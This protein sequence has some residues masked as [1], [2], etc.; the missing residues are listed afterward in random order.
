VPASWYR[1]H[2]HTHV[3]PR[4]PLHPSSSST[5]CP[6]CVVPSF[7][8]FPSPRPSPRDS[9]KNVILAGVKAVT[10]QDTAACTLADLG[11][12]FYLTQ[13]DVGTNRAQACAAKLQELNP[14]VAVTFV[15]AEISDDL[16]KKH[17]VCAPRA[18]LRSENKT[19]KRHSCLKK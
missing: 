4:H 19:R 17:Q 10:L 16:C 6:T 12:H 11:A 3:T 8:T 9:A 14:A 2:S 5:L 13:A 7:L 1:P 15:A 18:K